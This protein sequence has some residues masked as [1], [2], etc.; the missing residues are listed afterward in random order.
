MPKRSTKVKSADPVAEE[1]EVTSLIANRKM[2]HGPFA[3]V[4]KLSQDSKI[5]F[6][7]H[8]GWGRMTYIQREATEYILHK[9]ARAVCG[10]HMYRDHYLDQ[11]G[12][13]KRILEELDETKK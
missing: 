11:V 9:I 8:P 12:Y 1:D 4:A 3:E 6:Q 5:I 2:T 10:D 13:L 7:N